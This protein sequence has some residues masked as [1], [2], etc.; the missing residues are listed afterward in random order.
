[1]SPAVS[2]ARRVP[3]SLSLVIKVGNEARLAFLQGTQVRRC[4]TARIHMLTMHLG[5]NSVIAI[6]RPRPSRFP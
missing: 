6:Y 4:C 1:M 2:Q 3:V 5:L